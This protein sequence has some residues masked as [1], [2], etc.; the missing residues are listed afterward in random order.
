MVY[1]MALC[2]ERKEGCA[3]DE[4]VC[5]KNEWEDGGERR[6]KK[7]VKWMRLG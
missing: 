7:G 6:W 4:V 5:L 3:V 2:G 1:W